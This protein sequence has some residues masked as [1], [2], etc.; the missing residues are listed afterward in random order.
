MTFSDLTPKPVVLDV[1]D[2]TNDDAKRLARQG[3]PH[4]AAVIAQSQ[5]AGRGRM[6]RTFLSPEGGIYL[7]VVLRPQGQAEHLRY[8]PLLFADAVCRAVR[9]VCGVHCAIKWPNDVLLGGK[10]LAGILTEG[11]LAQNGTFEWL[12]CGV[13]LNA[14]AVPDG[15]ADI[16]ASLADCDVDRESLAAAIIQEL[17][18]AALVSDTDAMLRLDC[19]RQNCATLGKTVTLHDDNGIQTAFAE[20]IGDDGSLQIVDSNGTKRKLS[21]GEVLIVEK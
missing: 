1:T 7:S 11:A 21:S 12:V 14:S 10:K 3:A 15:V 16:A 8:L 18:D 6:G 19:V 2:S 13:G 4:G 20:T 17:T 9:S 5:T